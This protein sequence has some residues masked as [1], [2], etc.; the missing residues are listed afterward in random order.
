MNCQ[1]KTGMFILKECGTSTEDHCGECGIPLCPKHG[2]YVEGRILCP[3]CNIKIYPEGKDARAYS[4]YRSGNDDD[5]DPY[6]YFYTRNSFYRSSHY[7][8]FN[9]SEYNDFDREPVQSEL[10]QDESIGSIT[11]S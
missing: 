2:K 3:E 6:W 7:T 8:P 10:T 4:A 1:V 11:D 5:Y 9:E